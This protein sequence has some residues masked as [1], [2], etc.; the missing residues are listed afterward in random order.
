MTHRYMLIPFHYHSTPGS[1]SWG[2]ANQGKGAPAAGFERYNQ[3]EKC[4]WHCL[5]SFRAHTLR[6]C[7]VELV[8]LKTGWL[9]KP[10]DRNPR[11]VQ[12]FGIAVFPETGADGLRAAPGVH[13]GLPVPP[14]G[15][16]CLPVLY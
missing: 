6:L 14:P 12:G 13:R 3:H 10:T 11:R 16:L 7:K 8:V 9:L 15:C 1:L 5:L 4:S 2:N